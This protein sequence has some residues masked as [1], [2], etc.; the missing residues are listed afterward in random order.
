VASEY[1]V[2]IKLNTQQ[3]KRDLKTIGTEI[4]N[5][6]RKETKSSKTALSTT[7]TRLKTETQIASLQKR[8]QA[9]RN[10]ILKQDLQ[11]AKLTQ[12]KSK[13]TRADNQA[14]AKKFDLAKKNITLALKELEVLKN[15]NIELAKRNK[16]S[17]RMTAIRQG[18]FAGSGPGVFGPQP[19]K[20]FRQ[21]IG[22]TR[23]FDFQSA[24][25]SG[26]FPL[27][28]GQ[29][30][31]GALAGGLGGGIG[32]M[33][34]QMGGFAGGIAA[35][36]A[37]QTITNAI[38]GVRQFGEG[39]QDIDG[40]L[41][42]VT[43]KSLFSSEATEKRA[44]ALKKLGKQEELAK[45]LTQELT[46]TLGKDGL[47]R[48][49]ALGKSSKELARTFGQLGASLQAVLA[50][51]ILPAINALNTILKTFTVPSQFKNFRDSLSGPDLERFDEIAASNMTDKVRR[52][53]GKTIGKQL[54]VAGKAN[55]IAQALAEG[56]GGG[57]SAFTTAS[58]PTIAAS[59]KE[60]IDFLNRSLEVG[61]ERAE[62]ERKIVDFKNKGTDLSDVELEKQLVQINQLEKLEALYH[63]IGSTVR[64]GLVDAID[65]AITGTKSL[66]EI[67]S[68]V[69]AQ[70]RRSLVQF[71]V[72]SILGAFGLPGLAT[73]GPA[74]A[75]KSYIVGEKGPELFTPG[76]SGKVTP[77]DALGGSTNIVVNV[78]ASGSS[79][80]SNPESARKF[81]DALA[82]AIQSELI[83]QRRPG[84]LLR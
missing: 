47:Q 72:T 71:G 66:G 50:K 39:L 5:L 54:T 46:I 15:Q 26:G 10:G 30:P 57:E 82:I 35:T 64:D 52:G 31:V 23:G 65:S 41:A 76:V 13:L 24:L 9:I 62:L 43:E 70:L 34:G 32:G 36:A 6:G 44:A 58:D 84:G 14:E 8:T 25:I 40:A 22:A 7:N 18:N 4:S 53:K 49:Q 19:R 81:G 20:T 16:A 74:K 27:L 75:G 17:A 79:V 1:S 11:G 78:D 73:G 67:A 51:V 33:F 56:I 21:R 38:S 77:N 63:Q 3:V 68:S 55:T 29:G 61:R 60:R 80:E 59:L 45:L 2:N 83:K 28:F 69:F 12:I 37:L 42:T 48:V